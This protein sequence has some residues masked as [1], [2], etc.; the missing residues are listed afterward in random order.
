MVLSSAKYFDE[1]SVLLLREGVTVKQSRGRLSYLTS[2]RAKPITARRLGDDFDLTAINAAFEQ[3]SQQMARNA[4]HIIF[5]S[6]YLSLKS[7]KAR[8][9]FR[10]KYE[11]KFIIMESAQRY[12]KVS[13]T[14]K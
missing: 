9:K 12:F 7:D 1:F 3:K 13:S 11:S 8:A 4:R 10:E 2:D 5:W 6:A 14:Q